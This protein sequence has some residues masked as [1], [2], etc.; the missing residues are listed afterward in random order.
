VQWLV[1]CVRKAFRKQQQERRAMRRNAKPPLN[2]Q[3]TITTT[4]E[5]P[6][7]RSDPY[8]FKALCHNTF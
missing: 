3:T 6:R 8:F 5:Q 1:G 4:I 7:E 2:S